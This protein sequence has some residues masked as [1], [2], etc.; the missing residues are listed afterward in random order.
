MLEPSANLTR[1]WLLATGGAFV[2]ALPLTACQSTGPSQSGG[3]G[4]K[5]SQGRPCTSRMQDAG[6]CGTAGIYSFPELANV[7]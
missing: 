3:Q 4:A 6:Q 1:R 7:R 5:A 2:A